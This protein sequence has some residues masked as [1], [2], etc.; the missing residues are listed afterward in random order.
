MKREDIERSYMMRRC[1]L[2]NAASYIGD[3][4]KDLENV[5]V[6]VQI[7]FRSAVLPSP[8]TTQYCR[9]LDPSNK[10]YLYYECNNPDCTGYGFDLTDVLRDALNSRQ[11]VEGRM[12]CSGKEDWKYIDSA[13]CRCDT[14]LEY[15]IEPEFE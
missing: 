8:S 5:K 15:R 9:T 2:E 10:L 6:H 4:Y 1:M 3:Q 14:V 11:C 12:S 13:G 7:T